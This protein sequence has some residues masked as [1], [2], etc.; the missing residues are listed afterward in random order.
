VASP[1]KSQPAPTVAAAAP[2]QKTTAE[3]ANNL[4]QD[5]SKYGLYRIRL[6]QGPKAGYAVQV[7]VV[8]DYERV[9]RAIASY[10]GQALDNILVSIEPG[11]EADQ[12][13]F[14]ILLGPFD[15]EEVAKNFQ[16]NL[17]NKYKINGFLVN[18]TDK[19][20]TP[21]ASQGN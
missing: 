7:M 12:A 9:M 2:A 16:N 13:L 18:L 5:F 1:P 11:P 4:V 3:K 19:D 14:K 15:T 20:Y 17:K 6:E 8:S 10:Q 21:V